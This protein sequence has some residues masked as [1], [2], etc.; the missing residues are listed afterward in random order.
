[1][2]TKAKPKITQNKKQMNRKR[3]ASMTRLPLGILN[4]EAMDWFVVLC[5]SLLLP[6]LFIFVLFLTSCCSGES[7]ELSKINSFGTK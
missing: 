4:G 6:L 5:C 1:M 3:T 2:G 7:P